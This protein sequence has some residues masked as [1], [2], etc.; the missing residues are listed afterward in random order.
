MAEQQNTST[1]AIFDDW[2]ET[3]DCNNCAHYW[4][5][6][7][8]GVCKGSK[9]PCNSFLATRSVVIPSQINAMRDVIKGLVVAQICSWAVMVIL[10]VIL[11]G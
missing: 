4:D 7:C 9:K 3:V 2:N 1:Q 5:D 10:V 8:S 11:L 6:S